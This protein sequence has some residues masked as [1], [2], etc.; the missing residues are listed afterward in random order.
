MRHCLLLFLAVALQA[1]STAP[2]LLE[3]A[4]SLPVEVFAD[5]AFQLLPD[6][7][8]ATKI[9]TLTEIFE[10]AGEAR[11][12]FPSRY[13]DVSALDALS[14]RSRVVRTILPLDGKK[15][16]DL[17]EA[18]SHPK[19]P[20][21]TCGE[22]VAP[23]AGIYMDTVEAVFRQGQFTPLSRSMAVNWPCRKTASTV[24]M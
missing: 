20:R 5:I 22:A 24:S 17:F 7:S 1:Q 21:P 4:R 8:P 13:P 16:R 19:V 12:S 15:G 18:M 11:I 23:N 10:R 2:A 14:L 9:N 3:E 6:L